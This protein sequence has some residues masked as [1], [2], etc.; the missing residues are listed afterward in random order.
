MVVEVGGLLY[1]IDSNIIPVPLV[2]V[3]NLV[4]ISLILVWILRLP[5]LL[6]LGKNTFLAQASLETWLVIFSTAISTRKHQISLSTS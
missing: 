3:Q 4:E 1:S 6:G 5:Y 2:I